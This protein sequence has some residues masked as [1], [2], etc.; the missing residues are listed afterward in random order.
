[1]R[2]YEA[3]M[4]I[5]NRIIE[6]INVIKAEQKTKNTRR[7]YTEVRSCAY[8]VKQQE[9][10]LGGGNGG[11]GSGRKCCIKNI[12]AQVAIEMTVKKSKEILLRERMEK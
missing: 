8:R 2:V 1:M 4:V 11:G 12:K 6:T 7:K 10:C 3:R 9:S 5:K